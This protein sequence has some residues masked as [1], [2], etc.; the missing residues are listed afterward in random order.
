MTN[1]KHT[2]IA[3]IHVGKKQ[4][5]MDE[6]T[7]RD[8]LQRVTGKASLKLMSI[9]EL[10]KVVKDFKRLGFVPKPAGLPTG[11][12]AKAKQSAPKYGKKPHTT[13]NRQ[14]LI[15]KIEAILADKGLH[16]NYAHG[17][18]KKMFGVNRV[19]WLTDEKLYKVVQALAVYQKRHTKDSPKQP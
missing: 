9:D 13:T 19:N 5:G 6:A 12:S 15:N 7:Y 17:I 14:S 10:K 4:L 16:W 3:K 2:L 8:V 11:S 18:A 1:T